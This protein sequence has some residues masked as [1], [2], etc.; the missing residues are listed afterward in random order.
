[1]T[2]KPAVIGCLLT[3]PIPAGFSTLR[4]IFPP[5]FVNKKGLTNFKTSKNRENTGLF[6]IELSTMLS[7]L[8]WISVYNVSLFKRTGMGVHL[9]KF[10][11]FLPDGKTA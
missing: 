7:T 11:I 8:L 6:K 3:K 9:K 1:M 4:H 2:R 10:G 5:S